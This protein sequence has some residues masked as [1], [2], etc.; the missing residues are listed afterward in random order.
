MEASG[1]IIFVI[2]T[3]LIILVLIIALMINLIISGK[4]RGRQQMEITEAKL[5]FE[6]ELRQV[7][8]E[9]SEHVMSQFAQELHDNIGQLLTAMHIQIENQKLEHPSLSEGFKPVEIYL[10]EVTQHL[11]LLSRTLNNDYLGHIGLF[12]ALQLEVERLEALRRFTIHWQPI[13]GVSHLEKNQELMVFRIFQEITQNALRHS[14]AKNL[15]ISININT[16]F[17]LSVKDD[18]QGFDKE[19]VLIS[20]KASGLRNI[21][22]RS[23]LAGMLCEIDSTPGKGCLF[24]LKKIS[25]L[26]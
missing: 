4:R 9:V 5:V 7:E 14:G 20:G 16:G 2:Y 19:T 24:T 10:G 11:R 22:K 18:G 26:A 25:I 23:H 15:Y 21:I 13:S 17:E 1:L 6:R 8:T 3:T 12:S